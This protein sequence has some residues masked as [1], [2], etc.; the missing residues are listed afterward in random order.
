MELPVVGPALYFI[1]FFLL[2]IP[3]ILFLFDYFR[4]K[5]QTKGEG[6]PIPP[7]TKIVEIRVYPIKSC[8]GFKVEK[9]KLL[10]TG[11]DL[12]R[13]WMFV[14]AGKMSFLTIRQI[15]KMTLIDTAI[16]EN[17]ELEISIRNSNPTVR[18]T[19]PARPSK[20]W[21]EK[22]TQLSEVEIWEQKL[23]GFAYPKALTQPI[24]DFLEKDVRL[25]YKGPKVRTLVGNGAPKVLGRTE[26][27]K[28]ADLMPLQIS[29]RK[30]IEELNGRLSQI[31]HEAISIER[32]RPN[33]VVEG[34]SPWYEDTWK[35]IKIEGEG[36]RIV[37]DVVARCA[38]CQVPNV[39]PDTAVKDKKQPC[40]HS[41]RYPSS[42]C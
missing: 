30:S 24:S 17:D 6:L 23:D 21:L 42:S 4:Q 27:M 15:S 19:I 26:S 29:N 28:F 38:R 25:V 12:D 41:T 18:F 10:K 22:N 35:T 5:Q 13:Q 37:S 34:E 39:D 16:T 36:R 40:V 2:A 1:S 14:D 32:F 7:P 20:E 9:A 3:L 31:S 8:R 11:L 33:I